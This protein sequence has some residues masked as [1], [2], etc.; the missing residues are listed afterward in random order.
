MRY[1]LLIHADEAITDGLSQ[2]EQ[3]ARFAA[4]GAFGDRYKDRILGSEAHGCCRR[5]RIATICRL[6]T[7]R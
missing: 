1:A 3:G 4:Y 7:R 2:E 6:T 5:C